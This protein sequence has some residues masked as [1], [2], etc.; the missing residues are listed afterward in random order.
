MTREAFFENRI[1]GFDIDSTPP[2]MP[3]EARPA[4]IES[5]MLL[6]AVIPVMQLSV[7]VYERTPT[8]SCE[9]KFTSRANCGTFGA[10]V[11]MP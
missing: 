11:T 1:A 4:R 3:T 2:A 10:S 5:A 9:R 8:G 6:T 7:I